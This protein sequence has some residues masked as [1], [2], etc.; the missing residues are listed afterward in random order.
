MRN[1]L[2]LQIIFIATAVMFS[3]WYRGL[4]LAQA[5]LFG[6]LIAIT[7]ILLMVWRSARCKQLDPQDAQRHL[8]NF[9]LSFIERMVAIIG[10]LILGFG[11]LALEPTGL[12]TGFVVGQVAL[13]LAGFFDRKK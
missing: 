7:S 3:L 9:Y 1:I 4:S 8:R 11:P 2:R 13:I 10:L 5:V 6:G 12:L